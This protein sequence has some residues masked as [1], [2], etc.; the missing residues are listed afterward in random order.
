[1]SEKV[2]G[3]A[4]EHVEELPMTDT[5]NV[6]F[7]G[8]ALHW[9]GGGVNLPMLEAL[10]SARGFRVVGPAETAVL[11]ACADARVYKGERVAGYI[12]DLTDAKAVAQAIND[13]RTGDWREKAGT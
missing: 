13:W 3:H 12:L 1:M 7:D 5:A 9:P 6:K 10:L 4:V 8:R 11:K 2:D